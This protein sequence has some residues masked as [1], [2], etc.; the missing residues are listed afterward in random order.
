VQDADNRITCVAIWGKWNYIV[1]K[2]ASWKSQQNTVRMVDC[3]TG[4]QTGGGAF[5]I[6]AEGRWLISAQG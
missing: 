1:E 2:L 4:V 3:Q 5:E 6:N